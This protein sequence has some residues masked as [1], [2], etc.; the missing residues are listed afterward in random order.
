MTFNDKIKKLRKIYGE[1][2][3]ICPIWFFDK[4]RD[5]YFIDRLVCMLDLYHLAKHILGHKDL[6]PLHKRVADDVADI[7]VHIFAKVLKDML[8]YAP[9]GKARNQMQFAYARA[10]DISTRTERER[11]YL[12]FRGG[13]KTTLITEAH[14]VQLILIDPNIRILLMSGGLTQARKMLKSVKAPF[15]FSPHFRYLF[16]EYCPQPNKQGTIEFGTQDSFTV[17]NRY[18]HFREGTVDAA[19]LETRKTGNHWDY[20]KKDDLINETN[21]TSDEM[22]LKAKEFEQ[23]SHQLFDNPSKPLQDYIGTIYHSDDIYGFIQRRHANSKGVVPI[24]TIGS[25]VK[26]TKWHIKGKKV[27]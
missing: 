13:F 18:K 2:L 19:G 4:R 20:A 15:M 11:M 1:R 22:L 10:K 7:N 6:I 14:I 3:D 16:P 21:C 5:D 26:G 24:N 8:E 9:I 17:P 12:M 25:Y 23:H 27:A